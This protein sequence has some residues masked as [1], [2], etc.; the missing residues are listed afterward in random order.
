MARLVRSRLLALGSVIAAAQWAAAMTVFALLLS[1][2]PAAFAVSAKPADS[3]GQSRQLAIEQTIRKQIAAFRA[4]DSRTA[5]SFAA[6]AIQQRFG[7]AT[8][9]MAMVQRSYPVIFRPSSVEFE[10]LATG[11]EGTMI[12]SVLMS[13]SSGKIWV[14]IYS[15]SRDAEDQWRINGV[16]QQRTDSNLI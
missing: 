5:F 1:V 11:P 13:E 4:G 14:I 12:Q 6:P 9:F 2:A 16:Q 7:N 10:A 8:R 15:L 3:A